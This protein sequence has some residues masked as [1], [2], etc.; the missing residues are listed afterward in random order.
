MRIAPE[1]ATTL[2]ALVK[3]FG[4]ENTE[5]VLSGEIPAREPEVASSRARKHENKSHKKSVAGMKRGS[6]SRKAAVASSAPPKTQVKRAKGNATVA[7]TG[8]TTAGSAKAASSG[9]QK[10]KPGR[11]FAYQG[12][13]PREFE[14]PRHF[15]RR[16]WYRLYFS[17]PTQV[18]P[19]KGQYPPYPSRRR[20]ILNS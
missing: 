11:T 9:T 18:S 7:V 20:Y 8:T 13:D 12:F 19:P 5:I 1:N 3:E 15:S 4:L 17:G 6:Q 2:F 14:A 10:V 16:E